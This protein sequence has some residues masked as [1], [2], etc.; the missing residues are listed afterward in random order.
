VAAV[1]ALTG[2]A[3]V[4]RYEHTHPAATTAHTAAWDH[5]AHCESGGQWHHPPA[6][7]RIGTFSGGL[8]IMNSAWRQFGGGRYASAAWQATKGEQIVIAEAILARVGWKA[9][10]CRP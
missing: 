5:I 8:M 3:Q 4:A 9:W 7:N 1:L 10:S 2:C 6:H